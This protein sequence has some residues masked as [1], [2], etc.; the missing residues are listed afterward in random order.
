MISYF[1]FLGQEALQFGLANRLV[2]TGKAVESALE[3][4]RSLTKFP[5]KT[6]RSDRMAAIQVLI[7]KFTMNTLESSSLLNL[8]R[9]RILVKW[10]S[11]GLGSVFEERSRNR[12]GEFEEL[13]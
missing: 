11:V 2:P 1:F 7:P 3:L 4:A 9:S 12:V 10:F 13:R 6:M 8:L 5:Q